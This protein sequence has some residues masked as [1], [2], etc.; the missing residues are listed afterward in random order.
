MTLTR[1][2]Y[3]L[4]PGR[5]T[6]NSEVLVEHFLADTVV[7]KPGAVLRRQDLRREYEDWCRRVNEPPMHPNGFARTLRRAG[8]RRR[9]KNSSLYI[10]VSF[11]LA[12]SSEEAD[13]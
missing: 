1:F 2:P 3:P 11:L 7:R 6:H 5:W 9:S 8:L 4:P 13:Q 10:D 12:A